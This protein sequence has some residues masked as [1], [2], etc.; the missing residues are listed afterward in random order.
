MANMTLDVLRERLADARSYKADWNTKAQRLTEIALG[1]P[2]GQLVRTDV[3]EA[4]TNYLLVNLTLK[5][6]SLVSA[7]RR[8]RV[9]IYGVPAVYSQW[10]NEII[11]DS[12]VADVEDALKDR[13]ITGLGVLALGSEGGRTYL[14]RVDPL[15]VWWSPRSGLRH[16]LWVIRRYWVGDVEFY[17]YWDRDTHAVWS[18]DRVVFINPNLLGFIPVRFIPGFSVPRVDFP[19]GDIELAYPQQLILNEIRRTLLDQ[20]RRGVGFYEVA[21]ADADP[22]ELE[23]LR[24]P[25][26]IVIRTR[27]GQS[28]RPLPTPPVNAEWLQLEAIAKNDLDAQTGVSEYLRGSVPIANNLKFATQVLAAIGA[29][30]LRIEADWT[31]LKEALEW[32]A[33]G[34]LR[35]ANLNGERKEVGDLIADAGALDISGVSAVVEEEDVGLVKAI[36]ISPDAIEQT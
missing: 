7:W 15:D 33:I 12:A 14:Y 35:W 23:K 11:K 8:A 25:G 21:E 34:W 17:E 2:R 26:E 5:V 32:A 4:H 3:E 19:V 27:T 36:G 28:I 10:Y 24:E 6:A 13:F 22:L 1:V 30:N 31:P 20:A 18:E 16:P 9:R 29:Q